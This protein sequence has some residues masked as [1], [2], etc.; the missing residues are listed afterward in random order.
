[1]QMRNPIECASR[2]VVELFA[3]FAVDGSGDLVAGSIVGKG[4]SGVAHSSG[5]YTLTLDLQAN[6]LLWADMKT[7]TGSGVADVRFQAESFTAGGPGVA[8][9]VFETQVTSSGLAAAQ[10]PAS[11]TILVHLALARSTVL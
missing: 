9:V 10:G 7:L 3:K 2:N 1:M 11:D 8:T 5:Q 6:D 4:V